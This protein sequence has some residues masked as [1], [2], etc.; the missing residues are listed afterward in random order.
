VYYSYAGRLNNLI[1]ISYCMI[2]RLIITFIAEYE[3]SMIDPSLKVI[4]FDLTINLS[5]LL[6]SN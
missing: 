1:H 5:Q 6:K 2:L 4:E 3:F